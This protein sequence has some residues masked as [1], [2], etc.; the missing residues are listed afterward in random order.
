MDAKTST[1]AINN[2]KLLKSIRKGKFWYY[3]L[4]VKMEDKVYFKPGTM[5]TRKVF[6]IEGK[7]V[8]KIAI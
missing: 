1:E 3:N 7:K 2:I 8:T 4:Y 5:I 6:L